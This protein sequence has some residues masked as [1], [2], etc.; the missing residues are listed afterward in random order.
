MGDITS[1][2]QQTQRTLLEW[3]RVEYVVE[4]PSSRLRVSAFQL[5]SPFG[6]GFAA[7]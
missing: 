1:R 6:C 2:Q 4:K 3:L 5:H 7:L